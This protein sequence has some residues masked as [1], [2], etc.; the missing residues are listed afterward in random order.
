MKK[1]R[2]KR[3]AQRQY[4]QSRTNNMVLDYRVYVLSLWERVGYFLLAFAVGAAVGYIFYGDLFLRDGLPTSATRIS[5]LVVCCGAGVLAGV[6][7]LP[8]RTRQLLK[9]R[10][11]ALRNQFRDLLSSLAS[12]LSSGK[13][14]REAFL[15]VRDD[16]LL[17]YTEGAHILREVDEILTG[18]QN[19]IP[20]EALLADFAQRTGN[21]DIINFSSVFEVCYRRGGSLK[22]VVRR[23]HE[24]I[25][26]KMAWTDEKDGSFNKSVFSGKDSPINVM[27]YNITKTPFDEDA[28]GVVLGKNEEYYRLKFSKVNDRSLALTFEKPRIEGKP[29]DGRDDQWKPVEYYIYDIRTN[30]V[31]RYTLKDDNSLEDR[32]EFLPGDMPSSIILSNPYGSKYRYSSLSVKSTD[33]PSKTEDYED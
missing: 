5:N 4:V 31:K 27:T 11:D 25:S 19:N 29:A 23:T 22:D 16:L 21:S 13:N 7:F 18:L 8:I 26:E 17:Q 6:L 3:E 10:Q 1:P 33:A 9:K 24:V 32:G 12:S 28:G 30:D 2:E 20:I 14:V 15:N